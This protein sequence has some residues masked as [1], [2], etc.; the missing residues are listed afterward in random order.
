MGSVT[1]NVQGEWRCA[2][3]SRS[4]PSTDG[5]AAYFEITSLY[6]FSVPVISD[7]VA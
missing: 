2:D 7:L 1:I 6:T 3:L 4:V 5:L